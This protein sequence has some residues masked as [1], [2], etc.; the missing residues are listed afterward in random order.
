[1]NNLYPHQ[2]EMLSELEGGARYIM[3]APRTGKTRPAI[4]FFGSGRVLCLTKKAA[5][6]GWERELAA[7]GVSGW[8]VVNYEKVRTKGWDSSVEWDGL[9]LDEAHFLGTKP[10]PNLICPLVHKLKINGDRIALSAT[11][12]AE[13]YGQLF[14][15]AKSLRLDLWTEYK[16][17]YTWFKDYGISQQIR[18]HGRMVETYSGYHEKA[19]DEFKPFCSIVNRQEVVSDFVEAE[20]KLVVLEDEGVLAMCDELKREGV[21]EINGHFIVA[22]TT[23]A[24]AQKCQQICSGVVL[25]DAGIA[26]EVNSVKRDWVRDT[27]KG[28]KTAILTQ[29]RAEVDLLGGERDRMAYLDRFQQ[30]EVDWLVGNMAALNAGVDLSVADALVLTGCPW[31]VTIYIQARERLLRR[32]RDRVA[33]VYFPVIKGGIDEM[34]YSR[35]AVGKMDFNS[36]LYR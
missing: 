12:C 21:L 4:A 7:M 3:A 34:I 35:V 16:N 6:G 18:A 11:P 25:D 20:N 22:D 29:F 33:P 8:T 36:A 19:W 17:F 32:D 14:H 26:V 13:N 10:K 15:Q 30:G 9:V 24:L 2:K 27:F 23:L 1:M 28:V 5:I 31:S